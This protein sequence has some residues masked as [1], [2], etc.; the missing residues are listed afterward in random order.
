[1]FAMYSKINYLI[2]FKNEVTLKCFFKNNFN[3]YDFIIFMKHNNSTSSITI[4]CKPV[5]YK[6]P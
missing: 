3:M 5:L 6:Y 1:M 2:I 4:L